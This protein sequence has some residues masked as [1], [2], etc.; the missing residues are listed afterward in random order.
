MAAKHL[1]MERKVTSLPTYVALVRIAAVGTPVVPKSKVFTT[2]KNI[3]TV[4][5]LFM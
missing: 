4:F 1:V 2:K 3:N 5:Y